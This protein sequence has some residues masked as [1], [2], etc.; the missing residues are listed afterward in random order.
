MSLFIWVLYQFQSW[1]RDSPL[2]GGHGPPMWAL[3]SEM[4]A[5]TK[6]LGPVGVCVPGMPPK[7]ANAFGQKVTKMSLLHL[8]VVA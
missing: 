3:F 5:K 7:S 4:C 6:E 1:I 8:F 2:G